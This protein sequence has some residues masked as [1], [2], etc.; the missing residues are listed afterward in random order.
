M[1]D[2]SSIAVAIS[3]YKKPCCVGCE[4]TDSRVKWMKLSRMELITTI[5]RHPGYEAGRK[6]VAFQICLECSGTYTETHSRQEAWCSFDG[7]ELGKLYADLSDQPF[8]IIF[9][10]SLE[11][12]KL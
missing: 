12:T 8:P 11:S 10:L 5:Y 7:L 2:S 9:G 3:C 6:R 4:E 1:A